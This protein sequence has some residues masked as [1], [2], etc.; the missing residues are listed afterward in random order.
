MK[1]QNKYL[2]RAQSCNSIMC[3]LEY[4]NLFPP[5]EYQKNDEIILK[6]LQ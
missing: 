4:A 3:G 2:Y 1:Y 6:H 5:N